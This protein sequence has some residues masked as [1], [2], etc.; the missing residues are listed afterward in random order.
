M[1][2]LIMKINHDKLNNFCKLN[3]FILITEEEL[4][5]EGMY[6]NFVYATNNNFVG[7]SVYPIDMPIIINDGVWKKLKKVNND[8]KEH[9]KCITI[10]D[11][12]RPIQIQR[13]FWDYFYDT[14]GFHDESLVANPN[15]Y[16]THNITINAIDVLITNIDG[17][18]VELP[19]EFDDFT[20]K[21]NIHYDK[22]SDEAKKN[23]DLL[24]STCEKYGLIVNE[25]EWWHFY[26]ERIEKYGMGYN[27]IESDLIPFGE[28]EVF[29]LESINNSIKMKV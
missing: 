26:D 15:K 23:R 27:F 7:Q 14:H 6:K 24:I 13:L 22:C 8:L 28:D 16:G 25:D 21:A 17:T 4:K 10:Y 29:I 9:G 20:G 12:Y 5:K 11:A 18:S 2:N 3:N 19:S 1:E